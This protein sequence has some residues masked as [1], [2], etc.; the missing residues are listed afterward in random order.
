MPG[1]GG[2]KLAAPCVAGTPGT[3]PLCGGADVPGAP[4]R[5]RRRKTSTTAAPSLQKINDV[6][7]VADARRTTSD[8]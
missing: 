7:N 5:R 4:G 2:T 3:R 1:R 6:C 8:L